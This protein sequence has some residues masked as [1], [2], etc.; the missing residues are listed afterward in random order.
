MET[1]PDKKSDNTLTG[2]LSRTDIRQKFD[3]MLG[4]KS[5]GFISSIL[6]AVST[7]ANLAQCEPM[8]I[9]TSAAVAASLDLPI[10]QNLGFAHIVPYNNKAQFQ[11]G[12]RGF[13]QLGIRTGL[14]KTIHVATVYKDE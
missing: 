6:S 10:N 2:L 7:N 9:I 11:M 1:L 8:S 3:D 14:Y 4:R 13:V 5:A 12:W